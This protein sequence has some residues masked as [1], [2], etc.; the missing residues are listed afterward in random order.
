MQ[1]GK[2]SRRQHLACDSLL[3]F[4][5]HSLLS[6]LGPHLH[7]CS[8]SI[9][10]SLSLFSLCPDISHTSVSLPHYLFWHTSNIPPIANKSSSRLSALCT[11]PR[12]QGE[13][14]RIPKLLHPCLQLFHSPTPVVIHAYSPSSDTTAVLVILWHLILFAHRSGHYPILA[15]R[16]CTASSRLKIAPHQPDSEVCTP[17]PYLGQSTSPASLVRK[18][19]KR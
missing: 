6:R 5:A 2:N 17:E 13:S 10:V 16:S 11:V 12:L 7:S 1:Q 3:V 15:D 4:T 18:C 14:V 19:L 8:P 9:F